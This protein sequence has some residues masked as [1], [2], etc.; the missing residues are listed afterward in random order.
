MN[1]RHAALSLIL[2]LA[3]TVPFASADEKGPDPRTQW[4]Q[5]RGPLATGVAPVGDPPTTWSET[6]NVRWKVDLPGRGLSTPI[7]WG[8]RVFI[9]TSVPH[10]EEV[11]PPGGHAHGAHD[12]LSPRRRHRFVVMAFDREN[13]TLL[14]ER[15]VRDRRPHEATHVTGSWASQ[16]AVTD[17]KTLFVSFGSQGIYALDMQGQVL[18]EVDLVDMRTRHEHGEGSSPALHGE[19][20][21]VNW[22]HQGDSFVVALDT[23][24]GEPRWRVARDEITSWSTPLIV[25]HEGKAQ[26]VVSATHRIRSYDLAD[27]K[28]LWEASG[29]SR[30]VVA[31]PV[32]ADGYVYIG[33]SYDWQAMLAVRLAGASGDITKTENVVW[34]RDRDAPYVPSP[35]LYDDRLCFL[36]H[37]QGV[38][39]CLEARTG[40]PVFGPSRLPGIRNVFASPVGAAGRIYVVDRN[41][42]AVVIRHGDDFEVLA[43]NRLE[44]SFTASPAI[45]GNA[46][47]LRGDHHLYCIAEDPQGAGDPVGPD[48][49]TAA[50]TGR[51]TPD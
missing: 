23:K 15:T 43:R 3:L 18:W 7:V 40:K 51:R 13:G 46:L 20:L 42:N 17:G 21:V 30:N 10:G 28:L 8:D 49:G 33:N 22:D 47:Y 29:L 50:V 37:N 27:G 26:V 19:T 31:S 36:K 41:G 14:W 11:A 5:W 12:N 1:E 6:S 34:T 45:V 48:S 44:D 38:M 9:T 4:A 32:A 16:S 2:C 35:I 25:E 39:I 24:S